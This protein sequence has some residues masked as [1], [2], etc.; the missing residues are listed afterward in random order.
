MLAHRQNLAAARHRRHLHPDVGQRTGHGGQAGGD[1]LPDDPR[2][3]TPTS[4]KT[5]RASP[6]RS[7]SACAT[8]MSIQARGVL[9]ELRCH[10]VWVNCMTFLFDN[11]RAAYRTSGVRLK[12]WFSS[13][14]FRKRNWRGAPAPRLSPLPWGTS[15]AGRSPSM[16]SRSLQS[17]TS[18]AR[19]FASGGWPGPTS[20][21]GAR[22]TGRSSPA[23]PTPS[24]A[25]WPWAGTPA[26]TANAALRPPWAE[27][28]APQQIPV[29]EFLGRC[30]A[31]LGL[32]GGARENWPRIGLEA[33]AAGVPI[34]CAEPVGL[35]GNDRG[36]PDGVPREQ[37]RGNGLPA[38]PTRLRRGPAAVRWSSGPGRTSTTWPA[39]SGS[40]S[41]GR[42]SLPAWGPKCKSTCSRP[43]HGRQTFPR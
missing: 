36:R 4:S 29:A 1:R 8:A 16:K 14:S 5:F 20:T 33:M 31:M 21:S 30:H 18:R 15:S 43:F 22:T 38:G 23:C 24:A 7:W 12:P 17:P 3:A 32:N 34:G 26:S 27:T 39:R 6:A 37:R 28:L 40:A 10:L 9:K 13:P 19:T 11:E 42:D 35:E 2:R 25:A 41:S